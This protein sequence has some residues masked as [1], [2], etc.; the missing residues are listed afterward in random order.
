MAGR[1]LQSIDPKGKETFK[2][3]QNLSR[4]GRLSPDASKLLISQIVKNADNR[5]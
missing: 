1:K 4:Q 3:M 2:K 5:K